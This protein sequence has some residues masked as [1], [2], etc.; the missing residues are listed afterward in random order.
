MRFHTFIR[1]LFVILSIL[2]GLAT[3]SLIGG[4][5]ILKTKKSSSVDSTS[6]TKKTEISNSDETGGHISKDE[7]KSKGE[8]ER[9]TFIYP[10]RDTNIYNFY[11]QPP[12]T[13][14]YEKGKT[15]QASTKTDSGWYKMLEQQV[16]SLTDSI[17]SSRK[18]N[19]KDV[20]KETK[21]VGLIAVIL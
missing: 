17:S 7:S 15:E 21:G 9:T 2:I 8:Y 18:E 4:C 12:S 5:E 13:V 1:V 16:K 10:P 14:I 19:S 3:C 6:L 20:Q 11:N